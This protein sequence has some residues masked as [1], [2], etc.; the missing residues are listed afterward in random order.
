MKEIEKRGEEKLQFALVWKK[1]LQNSVCF[2][3]FLSMISTYIANFC[4]LKKRM[5]SSL[6]LSVIYL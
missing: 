2:L 1:I 5:K 6:H 4:D 3:I